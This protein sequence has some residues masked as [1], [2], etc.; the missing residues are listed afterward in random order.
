M[1]YYAF[2]TIK[3]K[4]C[5]NKCIKLYRLFKIIICIS[6]LNTWKAI[7]ENVFDFALNDENLI[8]VLMGN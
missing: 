5:S 8:V 6:I 4:L 3:T 7:V 1:N 2:Q